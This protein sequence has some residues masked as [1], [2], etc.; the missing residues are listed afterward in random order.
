MTIRGMSVKR[1][2]VAVS[3]YLRWA[4]GKCSADVRI[5]IDS[6]VQCAQGKALTFQL[7]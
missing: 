4:I 1:L 6:V 2:F 5:Y 3:W 7:R